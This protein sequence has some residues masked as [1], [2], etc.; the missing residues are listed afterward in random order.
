MSAVL[1]DLSSVRARRMLRDRPFGRARVDAN[2]A[3]AHDFTFWRGASG[4][5]Y[6]H[7]IYP[8]I[9]CPELPSANIVLVRRLASGGMDLV[10]V[11]RVENDTM[12]L[13]LAEIRRLATQVG[14]NEVH[15]HLLAHSAAGRAAIELDISDCGGI[16]IGASR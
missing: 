14:A 8:L 2:G 11:C 6:V 3:S 7:T 16:A 10:R 1:F 4:A 5:R 13:N 12:S 15:V 9:A